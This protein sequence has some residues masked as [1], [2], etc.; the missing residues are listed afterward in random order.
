M[1]HAVAMTMKALAYVAAHP[2]SG[3]AIRET[4]LPTPALR[5]HDLLVE[6][7]A[8]ATN[9]ADCKIRG[10]RSGT[11]QAPV[12]LGWD[13]AGV[14]VGV[15]PEA[16]GFAVGDEV[17]FAGDLTRAGCYAELVAVDARLVAH[18][19]ARLDFAEAAALPLTSLTAW[20]SVIDRGARGTVLVIGGAGGVGSIAIQLLKAVSNARVVATASRPET[21]AWC[22]ELGAD[23][24]IDHRG[25]LEG[26]LAAIGI[27]AV[28]FV[29]STQHTEPL[30]P[31]ITQ[32]LRPFGELALIDDPRSLDIV[33]LK[34]KSLTVHW[35]FMFTRSMFGHAM[36]SQ[37]EIL[38]KVAALIDA[39]A[40][41][42]TMRTRLHGF[43]AAHVAD[44]HAAHEAG[45][46]IGKIVIAR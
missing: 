19:P 39:R 4:E 27:P 6:V 46:A 32:V 15:G 29:L 20:E 31:Q 41:R 37:G 16:A 34:R 43:T 12:V 24:T 9:P 33:P 28:D 36:A 30:L 21:I 11:P 2:L 8:F 7:R 1:A 17:Y 10:T 44:A 35:E 14:V 22:K 18:K 45:T 26:Q 5:P 13:A 3:F 25:D 42:S 40:V 23:H 38:A